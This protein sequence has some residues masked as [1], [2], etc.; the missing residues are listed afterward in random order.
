MKKPDLRQT[1]HELDLT[2]LVTCYNEAQYIGRTLD[3]VNSALKTSNLTYEILIIDDKSKDNSADIIQE[4]V[5]SHPEGDIIFYIN[6]KNQGL[7]SNFVDGSY[8][9]RGKYYRL[10]CGDDVES[11]ELLSYVF[12]HVGLADVII[13]YPYSR[14]KSLEDKHFARKI[15]SRFY[16]YFANFLSGNNIKYY[17]GLPIFLRYDVMRWAPNSYGFGFQADLITR[18]LDLGITYMQIPWY[19]V[20]HT[21]KKKGATNVLSLRNFFSVG[22]SLLTIGIRRIRRM[23]YPH[24][25]IKPTEIMAPIGCDEFTE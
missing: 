19:N 6:D 5:D 22:H 1:Q 17:N 18:L 13:P 3:N 8:L 14:E 25:A 15:L 4:Y 11:K 7:C 9:G 2:V 23:L 12:K 24:E 21:P 20:K 16:I 10:C